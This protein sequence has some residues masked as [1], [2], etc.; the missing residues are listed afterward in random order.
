MNL[1]EVE[2][3][4]FKKISR[5][6]LSISDI[7]I[8]VGTNGSGKSSV[9]QA[10]HLACCAMRQANE[11]RPNKS[12]VIMTQDLDYLPTNNYERLG[13]NFVWSNNGNNNNC[14]EISFTFLD[15]QG[16]RLSA[17]CNLRAARNAGISVR[18]N[19]H[20]NISNEFRS[21]NKSFSAYIPGI[22]GIPNTEEKKSEKV[23]KKT[24]SFG[25]SNV[26]L[27]N[28]LLLLNERD[29]NNI[30]KIESWLHPIIGN[31]KFKIDYDEKNDLFIECRFSNDN[32]TYLPIELLGTGYLQLIQLFCYILLFEPKLLL[33]DEPDIHLHPTI[34]E[35]L[36]LNLLRIQEEQKRIGNEMKIF[37]STHS[38]FIIRGAT[39]NCNIFWLDNGTAESQNRDVVAN[40]MGWGIFGKQILLLTE[41]KNTFLLKKIISQWP[42]LE[43][44]IAI[45]PGN[46]Y[47]N[48]PSVQQ[49]KEFKEFLANKYQI[50]IHR[51]RD[52]LTN[53]E[54]ERLRQEYSSE[55][56]FLWVPLDSDVESYFCTPN[57]LFEL[58]GNRDDFDDMEKCNNYI[59]QIIRTERQVIDD[60]FA[61][62]R[63]AHNEK[64]Y[65][66]GGSP[67]NEDVKN[68]LETT[69]PL[70][71]A[72][73]K[74][75]FKRLKDRLSDRVFSEN[76]IINH[77]VTS[78]L[79]CDLKELIEQV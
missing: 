11:I 1:S 42:A 63:K 2:I 70:K 44:K 15:D 30:H 18:G 6:T 34:Q 64:L 75:I 72:K 43:S 27:R 14:S 47:N 33:I 59:N 79:A 48:L 78:E 26:I 39:E 77:D 5:I 60:Q 62:Q 53:D 17:I 23:I 57:F 52:S 73:G 13:H 46:G 67:T 7:N 19:I 66:S 38:P 22:S 76:I 16:S 9:L 10:L 61:K 54:V 28:V 74:T 36:I 56:I 21:K 12:S 31:I 71:G 25:D 41:D 68:E 3:R 55:G 4:N 51:D 20:Q 69:R 45:L 50:I 29:Q 32:L 65:Q 35:K 40:V 24:C 58:L 37:I 8:L 49:A